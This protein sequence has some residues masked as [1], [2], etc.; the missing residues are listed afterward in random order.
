V[1]FFLFVL[2]CAFQGDGIAA[3]MESY[4]RLDPDEPEMNV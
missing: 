3:D 1:L 4:V 2:V